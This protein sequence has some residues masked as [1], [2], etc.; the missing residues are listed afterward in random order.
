MYSRMYCACMHVCMHV[1]M[2]VF[3]HVYMDVCMYACTL[4]RD[5]LYNP[6]CSGIHYVDQASLEFT[7]ILL[8]LLPE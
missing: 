4:Y 7:E 5:S 2:S 8:P 1:G 6:G 3:V